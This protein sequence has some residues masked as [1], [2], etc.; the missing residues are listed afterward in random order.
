MDEGNTR[1]EI[2]L[3]ARQV[4]ARFGLSHRTVIDLFES[5]Q[6]AGFKLGHRTVRFAEADIEAYLAS[7]RVESR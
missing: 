3:D 6:L 2:L 4:A 1:G 7:R 5:G